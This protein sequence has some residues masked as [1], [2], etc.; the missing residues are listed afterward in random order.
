M[1][2]S[3]NR[4]LNP[5]HIAYDRTNQQYV[6]YNTNTGIVATGVCV[7]SACEAYRNRY[8]EIQAELATAD[9]IASRDYD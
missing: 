8:Y 3:K 7:E 9:F 2:K 5:I 1:P 6:A 4:I